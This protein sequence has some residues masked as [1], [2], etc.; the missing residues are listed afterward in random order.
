MS[1]LKAVSELMAIAALLPPRPGVMN[2]SSH[3]SSRVPAL[4]TLAQVCSTSAKKR[5]KRI[6]AKASCVMPGTLRTPKWYS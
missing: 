5:G 4:Q 3:T 1:A 2:S 6:R